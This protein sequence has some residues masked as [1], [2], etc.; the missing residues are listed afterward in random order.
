MLPGSASGSQY[1]LVIPVWLHNQL[2]A[3]LFLELE[4]SPNQE[5]Q[6]VL[7]M[8]SIHLNM[9]VKTLV[10][11]RH[12]QSMASHDGLT[13]VF[14]RHYFEQH[15]RAEVNRIRRTEHGSLSCI[16]I[17]IDN[18]KHIN[19]KFG[20]PVGD[21]ALVEVANSI[22][23]LIRAYDIC[24]RYG[25]DEFV[26]LMPSDTLQH[27]ALEEAGKRMLQRINEIQIPDAPGLTIGASIGIATQS[28][29]ILDKKKLLELADQAVYQAKEA[30]K[31]CLRIHSDEQYQFKRSSR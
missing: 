19:D 29:E 30:G 10:Q 9:A 6:S 26:V 24:A 8:T 18:F 28:S 27:P 13:E 20:H 2:E 4:G 11:Y 23:S 14:N 1:N 21:C 12:L 22:K 17:D 3:A 15:M 7:M 5:Q 31:N 16:F 25:G